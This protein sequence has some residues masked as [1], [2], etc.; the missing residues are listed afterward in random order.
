MEEFY[1]NLWKSKVDEFRRQ[2]TYNIA[3]A[4]ERGDFNMGRKHRGTAKTHDN[5]LYNIVK[6]LKRNP[7]YNIIHR[8]L[9]YYDEYHKVY[10]E[11]DVIAEHV[12]GNVVIFEYKSNYSPKTLHKAVNQLE[13]ARKYIQSKYHPPKIKT[14][15]VCNKENNYFR[16]R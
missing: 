10:G 15:Y 2:E 16:V 3:S 6:R 14:V 1:S 11:M 9:E 13:R 5:G 8:E 4:R 7:N 12:N